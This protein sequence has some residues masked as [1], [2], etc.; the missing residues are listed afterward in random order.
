MMKRRARLMGI[1]C[2]AAPAT[3][4]HD[5]FDNVRQGAVHP[6]P[7]SGHRDESAR[8][9][10]APAHSTRSFTSMQLGQV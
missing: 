6:V 8:G 9:G 5:S 3:L 1:S 7:G 10:P 2:G 4:S